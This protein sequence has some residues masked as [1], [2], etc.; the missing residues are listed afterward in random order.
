[1]SLPRTLILT[2]LAATLSFP[3]LAL[4]KPRARAAEAAEAP[5]EAADDAGSEAKSEWYFAAQ[6]RTQ[7]PFDD[8]SFQAMY[9]SG[10]IDDTTMVWWDGA[11]SWVP[12]AKASWFLDF[13]R[14]YVRSGSKGFGPL[15]GAAMRAKL[16][17]G[18]AEGHDVDK[19][20]VRM[21]WSAWVP[22]AQAAPLHE[23]APAT[24]ATTTA[25]LW[26][27]SPESPEPP[28]SDTTTVA[29]PSA[30]VTPAP[31]SA[32]VATTSA[33]VAAPSP[34][35][36]TRAYSGA[37]RS[38]LAAADAQTRRERLEQLEHAELMRRRG[39]ILTGTGSAVILTGT[40]MATIA[41]LRSGGGPVTT[42]GFVLAGLGLPPW[43]T[44]LA[45]LGASKRKLRRLEADDRLASLRVGAIAGAGR[46]GVMVGGRF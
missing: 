9:L 10:R 41:M 39:Y 30:A 29:T 46:G 40:T 21:E 31:A 8:A 26:E 17:K 13:D 4:A 1:M 14:W 22:L 28:A 43:I 44:G 3:A 5:A 37:R 27:P 25:P 19:L 18:R 7:G 11:E 35:V 32:E 15:T 2:G 45:L 16:A 6:G 23:R 12:L 36:P 33:P 20:E 38:E 42:A 34:L 24:V